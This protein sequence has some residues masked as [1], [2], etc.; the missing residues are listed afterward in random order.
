MDILRK[1][2]KDLIK[3]INRY[4]VLNLIREKGEITRT[5]I[6]KKCDFGMSTLT[7]IL[8]DLQQEGIILEGAETSSYFLEK[9]DQDKALHYLNMAMKMEDNDELGA[10]F[11]EINQAFRA[12]ESEVTAHISHDP[13]GHENRYEQ[14]LTERTPHYPE[15]EMHFS[16]ACEVISEVEP[17]QVELVLK[18]KD[19]TI[20]CEKKEKND[21]QI[22]EA[23]VPP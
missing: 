12:M 7:Y 1:G 10:I 17:I 11:I 22:W 14:Q 8:D 13:F 4:T 16:A 2:N 15:T 3:D 18:E 6:A 9:S 23:L 5:E 21:V 19:W 20:L